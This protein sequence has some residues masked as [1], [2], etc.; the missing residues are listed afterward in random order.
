MTEIDGNFNEQGTERPLDYAVFVDESVNPEWRRDP[1]NLLLVSIIALCAA[2]LLL[3]LAVP[4]LAAVQS[5]VDIKLPG[6]SNLVAWLAGGF[7]GLILVVT[8]AVV[9]SGSYLFLRHRLLHNIFLYSEVGCP[10]CKEQDLI[11]VRREKKD[12]FIEHFGVPVRRYVC[13]NCSWGGLRIGGPY[14]SEEKYGQLIEAFDEKQWPSIW[15]IN[16]MEQQKEEDLEDS[17][18]REHD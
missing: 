2:G 16:E 11:R 12:R 14:P 10:Q 9:G 5:V 17:A 8:L 18:V 1:V 7:K 13:R 6:I 4:L 15:E 3:L